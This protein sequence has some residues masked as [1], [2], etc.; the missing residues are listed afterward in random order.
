MF[1]RLNGNPVVE[2]L[3]KHPSAAVDALRWLLSTGARARVDPHREAFYEV[4]DGSRV[5]YIHITPRGKVLLLAI[6]DKDPVAERAISDR[7]VSVN[8]PPLGD[9]R[10]L[11]ARLSAG[12]CP[13]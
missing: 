1:L 11:S 3:R 13:C 2:D 6:W 4:E 7:R 8:P 5:F 10:T 9:S 12:S